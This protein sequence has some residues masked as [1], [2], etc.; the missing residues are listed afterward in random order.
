MHP[1]SGIVLGN[2]GLSHGHTWP[3]KTLLECN[4]LI[5]G[6]MHPV[7]SFHDKLGLRITSPVWVKVKCDPM[8]L[9]TTYLEKRHPNIIQ[10]NQKME[11]QVENLIIM[12]CFNSFLGGRPINQRPPSRSR[13]G[14]ILRA[15]A[16]KLESA[17]IFL[18]DGTY[19]GTIEQLKTVS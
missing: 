18:L 11:I 15:Q 17:E 8:Q 9:M 10:A 5:M 19:L 13:I 4:T 14:P 1:S 2:I 16:V 7:V 6:H 12:P 3:A